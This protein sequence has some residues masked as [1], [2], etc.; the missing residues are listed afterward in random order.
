MI[1]ILFFPIGHVS[2]EHEK[3]DAQHKGAELKRQAEQKGK[4]HVSE[5]MLIDRESRVSGAEVQQAANQKVDEMKP[6]VNEA[7]RNTEETGR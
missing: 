5:T 7:I 2:A 6:K 3:H 1:F 4:H